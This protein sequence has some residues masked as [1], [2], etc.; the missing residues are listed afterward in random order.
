MTFSEYKEHCE[1]YKIMGLKE[2]IELYK[3]HK[4][5]HKELKDLKWGEEMEYN[6][7]YCDSREESLYLTNQ[8]FHL[9]DEFNLG[10]QDEELHL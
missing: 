2:F 5:V 9:I 10:H 8:G 4:N 1:Q 3:A 6:L 7:F